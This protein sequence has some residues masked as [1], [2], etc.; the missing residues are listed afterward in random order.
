MGHLNW[1]LN[2]N[3]SHSQK[4]Q[5]REGSSDISYEKNWINTIIILKVYRYFSLYIWIDITPTP[6]QISIE[7]LLDAR[8]DSSCWGHSS[9]RDK[10]CRSLPSWTH[11]LGEKNKQKS[12]RNYK[13][14]SVV[15][16]KEQSKHW[17]RK[18]K[19]QEPRSSY[20]F[21]MGRLLRLAYWYCW[22]MWL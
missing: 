20:N 19:C 16:H 18:H 7:H 13:S 3:E 1:D 17:K 15:S 9:P 10:V 12:P 4:G 2:A 22:K 5:V 11:I 14:Q 6:F 8:H 21:F